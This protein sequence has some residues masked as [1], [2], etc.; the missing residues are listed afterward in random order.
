MNSLDLSNQPTHA[1]MSQEQRQSILEGLVEIAAYGDEWAEEWLERMATDPD[2]AWRDFEEED[3]A[4]M[5]RLY[6][7]WSGWIDPFVEVSE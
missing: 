7:G 4:A 2:A 1:H 5:I 3:R 6:P